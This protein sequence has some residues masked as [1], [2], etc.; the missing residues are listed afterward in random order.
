MLYNIQSDKRL[1]SS[2]QLIASSVDR[3]CYFSTD[4]LALVQTQSPKCPLVVGFQAEK[5][6]SNRLEFCR[7]THCRWEVIAGSDTSKRLND[8]LRQSSVL[9]LPPVLLDASGIGPDSW[10]SC[11]ESRL[12][13]VEANRFAGNIPAN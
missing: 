5:S 12:K 4:R 6:C 9:V 10:L 13:L 7:Q 1:P 2:N 3:R 11:T 8:R